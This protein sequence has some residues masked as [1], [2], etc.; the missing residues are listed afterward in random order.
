M[1]WPME[2]LNYHHLLYFWTVA[3]EGSIARACRKLHLAQPTI[4]GQLQRLEKAMGVKLFDRV[5][6]NLVLSEPGRMVYRYADEIFSLGRELVA[7]VN[8]QPRGRPQRLVVGVVDVLPK[9]I[10][11][12][13]LEPALRLGE[14]IQVICHEDKAERLFA[15]LSVQ[16]FD[17]V[18][19]DEP[20]GPAVK[21]RAFNHLLGE[22][23]ISFFGTTE[24]AKKY[25]RR[26]P[27]SLDGAPFV[28]PTLNTSLRTSLEG[29]FDREKIRP[30]I[31]G[32]FEDSALLMVFG[33]TGAGVFAMPTTI[34]FEVKR[35]YGV[36]VIGRVESVRERFYAISVER[37]IK[38]PG[39][40]AICETA[41]E[42][43]FR[44]PTG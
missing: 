44:E 10:A 1:V 3:R 9:L 6:R 18:L 13:L 40:V 32:E 20:P 22:C 28:L 27:Q 5:G 31:R 16:A 21:I 17:I 12:R 30:V 4:S 42:R 25:R 37:K 33:Q 29:W 2:W 24:L 35:Q 15:D 8:G 14:Q 41:R 26:F 23:G 34:E 43:L 38:H 11:Y 7:A 19:A 39:V 36:R